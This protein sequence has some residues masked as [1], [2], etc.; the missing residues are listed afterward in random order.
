MQSRKVG[1][2]LLGEDEKFGEEIVLDARK[3]AA[4]VGLKQLAKLSLVVF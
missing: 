3:M 2:K 1:E 4:C